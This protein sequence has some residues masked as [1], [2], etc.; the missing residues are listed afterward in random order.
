M[1]PGGGERSCRIIVGDAE[2]DEEE[3]EEEARSGDE[4]RGGRPRLG[5]FSLSVSCTESG[6]SNIEGSLSGRCRS[7]NSSSPCAIPKGLRGLSASRA[8][9]VEEGMSSRCRT[10]EAGN[11]GIEVCAC[12]DRRGNGGDLSEA[13]GRIWRIV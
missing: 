2:E 5:L 8:S 6:D 13:C 10:G 4:R 7:S 1:P 9:T 3:E 12:R 11:E